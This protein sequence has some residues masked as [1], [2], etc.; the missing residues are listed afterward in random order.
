MRNLKAFSKTCIDFFDEVV[1]SKKD[2]VNDPTYKYRISLLRPN[3]ENC[4]NIYNK[5]FKNKNLLITKSFGYTNPHKDD[6]KKLYSYRNSKIQE[7]KKTVTTTQYNRIIN[8]CQN[9][10]INEAKTM[11][12]VLPKEDFPEFSIHP[13]NLF[14]SCNV[15][16]GHK[17]TNWV[18]N[19]HPLFLNLY[20]DPLPIDQYLFVDIKI[21]LRKKNIETNFK[22]DNNSGIDKVF[23]SI[24]ESHY[25]KL[26]LLNRF[27]NNCNDTVSELKNTIKS[28]L[29]EG[30]PLNTIINVIKRKCIK[31]RD[32]LG[33]NHWKIILTEKLVAEPKFFK[34]A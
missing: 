22:L 34:L 26:D 9:C 10:T 31:D 16:N 21:D 29:E 28:S 13:Q 1:S 14:P 19:G 18:K 8:T 25:S 33:M 24:I 27:S 30:I 5:N 15:C 12:H 17:S 7:L 6:L 4:Y 32:H 11:D 20:L 23:Y 3:V 2:T